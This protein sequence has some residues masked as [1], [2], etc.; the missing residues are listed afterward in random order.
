MDRKRE[1]MTDYYLAF[2]VGGTTIKYGLVDK[3]LNI[4]HTGIKM[5]TF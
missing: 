5:V 4:S 3:N 2:D 1:N